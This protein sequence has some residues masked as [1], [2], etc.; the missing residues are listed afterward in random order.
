[1][2]D[3]LTCHVRI[4]EMSGDS[5]RLKHSKTRRRKSPAPVDADIQTEPLGVRRNARRTPA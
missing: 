3:R 5:Y 4:Q 2:V 1:M